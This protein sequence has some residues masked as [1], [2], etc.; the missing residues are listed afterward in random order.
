MKKSALELFEIASFLIAG[1]IFAIMLLAAYYK[2][3]HPWK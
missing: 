1:L 2:E 3:R